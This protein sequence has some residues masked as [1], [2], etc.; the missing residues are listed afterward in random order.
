MI[1]VDKLIEI[2]NDNIEEILTLLHIDYKHEDGWLAMNC[3]FHNNSDGYNLKFRNGSFYCFSQCRKSYNIINVV[4]KVLGVNFKEAVSWLSSQ[5][6][7]DCENLVVDEKRIATKAKLKR[8]KSLK[9]KKKIIEYNN[10]SQDV[11][12]DIDEYAHP[13]MIKQG[14]K[15]DTLRHF[16]IGYARGGTLE[17]RITIPID[18]INGD[19]ISI[20][21]RI[22]SDE[23]LG[24]PRYKVLGDTDKSTT[25]YNISRLNPGDDYVIVVEG[26][27]SVFDLYQYGYNNVVAVMGSSLSNKQKSLLLGLGKK[28]IVIG[29]N[30]ETGR[31]LSQSIYNQCYRFCEVVKIDLGDITSVEKAS[32]REFDIGFEAMCEL[33]D[34]IEEVI[35]WEM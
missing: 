29:D 33:C 1:D 5:L 31:R 7:L 28:I 12:N 8:L 16:N 2:S 30:D 3:M 6:N 21:G 9:C 4:Q 32:P 24:V 20:S 23:D 15:K 22:P 35:K 14:I 26:F 25:L 27:M 10:V 17:G 13:Y 11:L 18:N 19:V 34:K